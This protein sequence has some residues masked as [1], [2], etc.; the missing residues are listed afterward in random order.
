VRIADV[1][2]LTVC[3]DPGA[4]FAGSQVSWVLVEI[5]TDD[6]L[7]G[8][9]EC[10]NWPGGANP[11]VVATAELV[12]DS[13]VGRDPGRIEQIWIELFRRFTYLGS[14]GL[15]TAAI[16]GID[17]ALW[18]LKG[19]ALGRPVHDL[20]GG[21]VRDSIP[22]YTHPG[23]GTP[24]EAADNAVALMRDGYRAFKYDPFGE[25]LP[26]HT[27]Y[28]GGEI[29]PAGVRAGAEQIDAVRGAVGPDVDLLIDFHGNYNAASALRCIRAL[30]PF[31]ITW[32]EEPFPPENLGALRQL[33]AQ[34][35]APLCV[36]E[37]L[38]TRWDFVPVL[39]EGLA[40]YLM[41]DVCWTGGISELRKIATMAEAHAVPVAP[42]GALGPIQTIAA[43]HVML[44]T[45][46]LYRQ[47]IL[48]PAWQ[49]L[50]DDCL[51]GGLDVRG[52]ELH[53]S[54]APGLGIELDREFVRAHPAVDLSTS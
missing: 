15:V 45:P 38:Y 9:G 6:G 50:Y 34:T 32:F 46:N 43:A 10:S 14:R 17:I 12:R 2:L 16:S 39:R 4:A 42:H 41:P 19:K 21:A 49:R 35:D 13:L 51:G 33:R 1:R 37:R 36:G 40:N 54:D 22:L 27:A 26:F 31:G 18:D 53:L 8:V 48:A 28:L 7:V 20:L 30:E 3:P 24:R 29:S 23:G 52:G 5:E 44:A 25:M 47:E 11:L